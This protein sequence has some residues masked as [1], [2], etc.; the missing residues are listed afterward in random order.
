MGGGTRVGYFWVRV[1]SKL[2]VDG[3]RPVLEELRGL[4]RLGYKDG[5]GGFLE[6]LVG[7]VSFVTSLFTDSFSTSSS[8]S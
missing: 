8:L 5:Y 2:W 6:R 4:C 1:D 7:K 3:M